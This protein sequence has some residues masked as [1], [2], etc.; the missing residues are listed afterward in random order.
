MGNLME[1]KLNENQLINYLIAFA[2]WFNEEELK[3]SDREQI[4]DFVMQKIGGKNG[5]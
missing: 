1:F 3:E 4:A 5:I 2:T